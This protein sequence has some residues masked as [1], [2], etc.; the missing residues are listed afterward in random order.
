MS[1]T[2][3]ISE[4]RKSL[5]YPKHGHEDLIEHLWNCLGPSPDGELDYTGLQRGFR[6]ID[7]RELQCI[8]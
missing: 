4:A 8:R 2:T 5:V 1:A 3:G 7:H 6:K